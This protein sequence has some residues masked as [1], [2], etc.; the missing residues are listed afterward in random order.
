MGVALEYALAFRPQPMFQKFLAVQVCQETFQFKVM[1]FGLKIG[2]WVFTKK[3]KVV[4]TCLVTCND[5]TMMYLDDWLIQSPSEAQSLSDKVAIHSVCQEIGFW[6]N[7]QKSHLTPSQSIAWLSNEWFACL[8][9]MLS[10]ANNF[11]YTI[12]KVLNLSLQ[13]DLVTSVGKLYRV[14]EPRG[15][16]YAARATCCSII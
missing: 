10:L 8:A 7:E 6:V 5:Q 2:L 12:R 15:Q 3:T 11:R 1:P 16:D 4:L 9:T 14:L 13:Y